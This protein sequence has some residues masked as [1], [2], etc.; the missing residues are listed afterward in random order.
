MSKIDAVEDLIENKNGALQ[1]AINAL[2]LFVEPCGKNTCDLASNP[3]YH[4][5]GCE[6]KLQ[7]LIDNL[8]FIRET[9]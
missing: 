5:R 3:P 8:K 7:P 4:W 1:V 6:T 9:K 2:S